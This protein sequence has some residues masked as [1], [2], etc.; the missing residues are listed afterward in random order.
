M[1]DW[2]DI[3]TVFLDMDGTLLD[4]HYDNHFW[5]E[6]VPRRYAEYKNLPYELAREQVL[7]LY[8]EAEG[9][10]NWY[11]LDYWSE[12]LGL[13]IVQLSSE[14]A[15]LIA[16]HPHVPE[17]LDSLR[18]R[19]KRVSLVT[20]AHHKSIELK[21]Q[22]TRLGGLLERVISSHRLGL[23]K[24][25]PDFWRALQDVESY[26]PAHTLLIDDSL[27]VLRAARDYG[28]AWLLAVERPDT[29]QP[30]RRIAEFSVARGFRELLE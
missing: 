24:E 12:K 18:Q 30:A 3:Q 11:C 7:E 8:R 1:L 13:D 28:I 19:G 4:L 2:Q 26:A 5:L 21:M 25:H 16:E 20:N 10:L 14:V 23:P 17:F 15:H 6:H 27:P 29:R 9:T 22:R